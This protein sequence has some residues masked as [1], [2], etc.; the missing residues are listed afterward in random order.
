MFEPGHATPFPCHNGH[1]VIETL[2]DISKLGTRKIIIKNDA[3]TSTTFS[4]G[5]KTTLSGWI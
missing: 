5:V 3:E 4:L 1:V 2:R